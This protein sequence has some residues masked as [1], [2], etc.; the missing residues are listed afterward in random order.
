M[1]N[2]DGVNS[3]GHEESF[4]GVLT[5]LAEGL[6][7]EDRKRANKAGADIFAAELKA[8]TPRSDRIYHDGTPHI[9]DAVLVITEPSGRVDVGY[10]DESKRGY[11]ARFQNDGWIVTDRNGYSHKHVPGKHF[12]EAAELASKDRIQEAIRQSLEDAFARKVS[13]K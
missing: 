6:T 2:S 10:S 9:Q 7:L 5:R 4:E 12:W 1:G 3:I 11:I 13:G 8:K